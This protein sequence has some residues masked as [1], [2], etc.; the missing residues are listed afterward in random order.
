MQERPVIVRESSSG[1]AI[2]GMI[3]V[4]VIVAVALFA[5][6][7]WNTTTNKTTIINQAPAGQSGAAGGTAGTSGGTS[8]SSGSSAGTSGGT[9]A[10][11]GSG[12]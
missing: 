8:G 12:H 1:L 10:G 3:A 6:Q 7:P 5:W 9:T 4:L 11:G 2:F